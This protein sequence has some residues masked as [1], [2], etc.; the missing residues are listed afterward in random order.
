M[1]TFKAAKC[2]SCD[3]DIQ[4]PDDRN[5][6]KCMYCGNDIVIREAIKSAVSEINLDNIFILAGEAL[7]SS[8][9]SEAYHYYTK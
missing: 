6:V 9:Y 7:N 4:V 1:T 3:G 8:N 5:T 2:P